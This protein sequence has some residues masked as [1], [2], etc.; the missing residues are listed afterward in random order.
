MTDEWLERVKP[1][2]DVVAQVITNA[3]YWFTLTVGDM[4]GES[5]LLPTGITLPKGN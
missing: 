5:G 1:V 4:E 3:D 2:N